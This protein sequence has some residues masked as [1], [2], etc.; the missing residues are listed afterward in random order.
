MDP[1]ALRE[2]LYVLSLEY[3]GPKAAGIMA[4]LMSTASTSPSSLQ[5]SSPLPAAAAVV[6]TATTTCGDASVRPAD[7]ETTHEGKTTV[8]PPSGAPETAAVLL[9]AMESQSIEPPRTAAAAAEVVA[10]QPA[11]TGSYAGVTETLA[12][13]D[14][15]S[16]KVSTPAGGNWGSRDNVDPF[17]TLDTTP[18]RERAI[19][20]PRTDIHKY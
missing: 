17:L 11:A 4:S 6:A 7:E 19:G 10:V 18:V 8:A 14:K 2:F 13:V 5:S 1:F 12:A 16:T 15:G 20:E 3:R 9:T